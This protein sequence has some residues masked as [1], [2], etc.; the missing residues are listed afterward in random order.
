VENVYQLYRSLQ[1]VP[2]GSL[3]ATS[4]RPSHRLHGWLHITLLPWLLLGLPWH[5]L[6][7]R[8]PGQD[9][10]CHP[11]LCISL[12]NHV[13]RVEE[14]TS[15][16]PAGH[17]SLSGSYLASMAG[18]PRSG[19]PAL[20]CITSWSCSLDCFLEAVGLTAMGAVLT[21]RESIG[22]PA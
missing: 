17:L 9:H 7:G 3:W 18:R 21:W 8:K 12:Y 14:C 15:N 19:R 4:H 10:V 11:V 1:A 2:K 6:Q 13:L 22:R 5:R 20:G 16:I